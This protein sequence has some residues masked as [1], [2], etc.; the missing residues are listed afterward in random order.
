MKLSFLSVLLGLVSVVA[1][2]LCFMVKDPIQLNFFKAFSLFS[3][4]GCVKCLGTQR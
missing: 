3:L 4:L 1:L 2:G